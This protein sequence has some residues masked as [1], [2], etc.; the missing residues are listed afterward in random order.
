MSDVDSLI[1]DLPTVERFCKLVV[2]KLRD[3]EVLIAILSARKKYGGVSRSQENLIRVILRNNDTIVNKLRK[4]A[5][6]GD[7]YV[8]ILTKKPIPASSMALYIDLSPKSTIKAF[9]LFNKDILQW[10][11]QMSKD[12]NFNKSIF[13][14][15]DIKLFSAIHRSNSR[16]PP[17]WIVDIDVKNE[18]LL[19]DI[20]KLFNDEVVWISETHGGYHVIVNRNENTG[21]VMHKLMKKR[22][23]TV[24]IFGKDTMTVVPGTLQGGFKV[25][26]VVL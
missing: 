14:K 22:L 10:F 11:Y 26:E 17:Y 18:T 13:R 12:A 19:K 6:V 1:W 24:E 16:T 15:M 25:R 3:D 5:V 4:M 20:C 9:S 7:M 21:K 2:P 23:K 8:D